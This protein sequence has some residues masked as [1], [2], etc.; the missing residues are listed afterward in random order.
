MKKNQKITFII[1]VLATA[2]KFFVYELE[3][4]YKEET[5][6]EMF[7]YDE[8]NNGI[9][10][11]LDDSKWEQVSAF[12][13]LYDA[14]MNRI[15]GNHINNEKITYTNYKCKSGTIAKAEEE[16]YFSL[17][18]Y[19]WGKEVNAHKIRYAILYLY[20]EDINKKITIDIFGNKYK[21]EDIE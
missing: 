20:T 2:S 16:N 5:G 8:E 14:N 13:E 6:K 1:N 12:M 11:V 19:L 15:S 18:H 7:T 3:K 4:F 17:C 10:Q 21:I 9:S